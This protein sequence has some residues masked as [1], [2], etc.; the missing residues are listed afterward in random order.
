MWLVERVRDD[1]ESETKTPLFVSNDETFAKDWVEAATI[2]LDAALTLKKP[3]FLWRL[4]GMKKKGGGTYTREDYMEEVA[5]YLVEV[6]KIMVLD[7]YADDDLLQYL[8]I[9][10]YRVTEVDFK[11]PPVAA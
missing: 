5:E 2:E 6:R 1:C 8:S 9:F 4:E 7:T 11:D 10:E 3:T